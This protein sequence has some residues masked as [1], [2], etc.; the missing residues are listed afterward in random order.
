MKRT[1]H[2][3]ASSDSADWW[4]PPPRWPGPKRRREPARVL[5]APHIWDRPTKSRLQREIISI[6][7]GDRSDGAPAPCGQFLMRTRQ[8]W[9]A[10]AWPR[11]GGWVTRRDNSLSVWTSYISPA[12]YS[13][14]WLDAAASRSSIYTSHGTRH[15]I[16]F[17]VGDIHTLLCT[18]IVRNYIPTFH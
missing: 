14:S 15:A 12:L 3:Y 7:G 11:E 9:P 16:K 18:N 5:R 17:L 2:K 8:Q 1:W 10:C 4:V 6:F 13:Y